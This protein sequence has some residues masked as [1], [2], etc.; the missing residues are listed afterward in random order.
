MIMKNTHQFGIIL[1]IIKIKFKEHIKNLDHI[2]FLWIYIH[3]L[4]KKIIHINFKL[5]GL[6][7]FLD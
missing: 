7:F 4:V 3:F 1:L 6:S 2:N 5:V